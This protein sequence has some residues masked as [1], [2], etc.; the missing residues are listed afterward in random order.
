MIRWIIIAAML[1]GCSSD[2]IIP[3]DECK[4]RGEVVYDEDHP[5]VQHKLSEPGVYPC[6]ICGGSGELRVE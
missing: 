5:I 3:C 4:G 2:R 1:L 6:P